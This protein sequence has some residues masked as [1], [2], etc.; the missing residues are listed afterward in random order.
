MASWVIQ[1]L[2]DAGEPISVI[3]LVNQLLRFTGPI[4]KTPTVAKLESIAMKGE[5]PQAMVVH[6]L[7]LQ[8]GN[9]ME[10]AISWFEKAMTVSK[11]VTPTQSIDALLFFKIPQAWKAYGSA[12][13]DMGDLESAR[14]AVAVGAFEYDN[15]IAYSL[16]APDALRAGD[17]EKYEQCLTKAAMGDDPKSCYELGNLYLATYLANERRN[18]TRLGEE[19]S[20]P[21]DAIYCGAF[22]KKYKI[23]EY[24]KLAVE[25]YEVA[26][27]GGYSRAAIVMALML[28]DERELDKG[29]EYLSLAKKDPECVHTVGFLQRS[30]RQDDF[31]VD[32]QELIQGL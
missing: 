8:R 5:I 19:S 32:L 7:I 1:R 15:E 29:L 9:R 27:A 17:L 21:Q 3:Y 28:R 14:K 20:S 16:L 10:E 31:K 2:A 12:K 25:W 24:R 30:W 13:S 23:H 11:P 22:S 4:K 26:I 6:G 18:S